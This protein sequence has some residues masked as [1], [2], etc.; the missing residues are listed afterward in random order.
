MAS[1][2]QLIICLLAAAFAAAGGAA[3]AAMALAI[4][5]FRFSNLKKNAQK[6]SELSGAAKFCAYNSEKM[7]SVISLGRRFFFAL[8]AFSAFFAAT[9]VADMVD[10]GLSR[11]G[12]ITA[13]LAATA[14]AL[15]LQYACLDI[16]AAKI[17]RNMPAQTIAKL[18]GFMYA[19]FVFFAPFDII[20]RI[21]AKKAMPRKLRDMESGFDYIDVEMMLRADENDAEAITPYTGKIVKNAFKLQEL[22]VSDVMLPRSQVVFLDTE[23]SNAENIEHV[24]SANHT[25][26][27]ICKEDLDDCFGIV[28]VKDIFIKG[29]MQNP[30]AINLMRLRRETFRVREN[31]KLEIALA[32]LLKYRLHM[33][34]VE[35]EFG[36]VIGVLTLDAALGELVGQQIRDE[37]DAGK[38]L[39]IKA[40]GRRKYKVSGRAMLRSV[41]DFLDVDF[42]TDEVSTFGG[43]VTFLL[44]RF[45][46]KGER[47]YLKE[48]RLRI[49]IDSVEDKMV[50]ECTVELDDPDK[51]QNN[52]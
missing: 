12:E 45:P 32:K 39:D 5:S 4:A 49:V 34:L 50:G 29:G 9:A 20:A 46:E 25:R 2:W 8:E 19:A 36:G 15:L 38:K 21:I 30:D 42:D 26:Y 24:L 51:E 6:K 1:V 11:G 35:D 40:V 14:A 52:G 28:H 33:A 37:F 18:G 23:I 31:D 41:E 22:D 27:P 16:P 3:G 7:A 43:L 17:G 47:L 44:G 10:S 13:A 48:Q